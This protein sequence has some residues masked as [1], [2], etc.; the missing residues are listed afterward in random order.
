MSGFGP[1]MFRDRALQRGDVREALDERIRVVGVPR[2]IALVLGILVIVG[3]LAWSG[4]KHVESTLDAGGIL[5]SQRG[6]HVVGAPVPGTVA[7]PLPDIGTRVERGQ[8]L[9]SIDTGQGGPVAVKAFTK[10][11]VAS[12]AGA[13][14]TPVT[15][16][17]ELATIEP[18]AG[19]ARAFLFVPLDEAPQI[20]EG[21][22]V[23]LSPTVEQSQATTFLK[24][25]VA[26][27]G[28]YPATPARL[29]LLLGPGLSPSFESGS[30]V[31]EVQIQLVRDPSTPTGYA[32]TRGNGPPKRLPLETPLS[33]QIVLNSKSPLSYVF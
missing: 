31:V 7:A 15:S 32:W 18:R 10:G 2:W 11:K 26:D 4:S 29:G 21:M 16:G 25:S 3:L 5:G 22:K 28:T 27:V 12:V 9:T 8:R 17:Q 20:R 23:L 6:I 33:G 14:G 1:R 30:P 24:G 13:P 19:S